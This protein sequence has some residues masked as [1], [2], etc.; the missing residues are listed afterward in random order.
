MIAGCVQWSRFREALCVF[1]EMLSEKVVPNQVT[2]TSVLSASTRLGALEQGRW[3]AN[4]TKAHNIK[5]NTALGTALI[6]MYA[7]CG[8]MEEALL[9]F[10]KLP[11]KDIYV[12]TAMINGLAAHGDAAK[13][14][15]FFLEMLRNGLRSQ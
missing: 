10:E 2:L 3:I 6:D 1:E 7:K 4:Y 5:F 8:C 15:A 13:S 9:V 14:M 11:N 12:W